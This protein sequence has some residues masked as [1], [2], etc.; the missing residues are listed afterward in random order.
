MNEI[1]NCSFEFCFSQTTFSFLSFFFYFFLCSI[2]PQFLASILLFA[3]GDNR[4]IPPGREGK[5]AV[6]L[7]GNVVSYTSEI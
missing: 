7:I 1:D 2:S 4:M 6:V 5:A 3:G